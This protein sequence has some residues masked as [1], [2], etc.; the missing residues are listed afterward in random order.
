MTTGLPLPSISRLSN[1]LPAFLPFFTIGSF[2]GHD[3][4]LADAKNVP[5]ARQGSLCW[6]DG[7]G[8]FWLFGGYGYDCS[9]GYGYLS[10]LWRLQDFCAKVSPADLNRDCTIDFIDLSILA[11]EWGRNYWQ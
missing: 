9:G 4:G 6:K 7:S 10:A 8:D 2:G 1:F 5:G 3:R 11:D